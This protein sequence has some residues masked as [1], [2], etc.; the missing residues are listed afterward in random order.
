MVGSL[1]LGA[2]WR[3][4]GLIFVPSGD[5]GASSVFFIAF[6][7]FVLQFLTDFVLVFLKNQA[8]SSTWSTILRASFSSFN[9]RFRILLGTFWGLLGGMLGPLGGLLAAIW[10]LLGASWRCLVNVFGAS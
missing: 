5:L 9:C 3:S 6:K 4:F 10:G 2:F 8:L 7:P 1:C